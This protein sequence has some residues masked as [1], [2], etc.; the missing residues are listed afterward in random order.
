MIE[1]YFVIWVT[2]PFNWAS[3]KVMSVL[4]QCR[5]TTWQQLLYTL[6]ERGMCLL[7]F[8]LLTKGW[9]VESVFLPKPTKLNI[10]LGGLQNVNWSTQQNVIPWLAL[11]TSILSAIISSVHSDTLVLWLDNQQITLAKSAV[12]VCEK[13][14]KALK[15]SKQ[16]VCCRAVGY[17]WLHTHMFSIFI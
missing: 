4:S 2:W 10:C 9:D 15:I 11:Q 1:W 8:P 3:C 14:R 7:L 5:S 17:V 6:C 16:A 13:D 12:M